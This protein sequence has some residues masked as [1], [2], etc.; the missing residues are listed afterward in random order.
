MPSSF[1]ATMDHISVVAGFAIS[2]IIYGV[3]RRY[4]RISLADVPGPQSASFI[5]GMSISL[6]YWFSRL[7]MWLPGNMK[8]LYQGQAAEADF[9]WQV[10]YG[11]VV[12]FKGLFGVCNNMR[13]S[14]YSV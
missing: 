8:E 7:M 2:L 13:T 3:Y 5:M 6:Q 12:R 11:N 10:Q 1:L 4:T 9:K 14:A